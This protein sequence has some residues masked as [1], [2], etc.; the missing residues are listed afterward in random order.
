MGTAWSS[1]LLALGPYSCTSHLGG[2]FTGQRLCLVLSFTEKFSPLFL[3]P[4]GLVI[5]EATLNTT[6]DQSSFYFKSFHLISHFPIEEYPQFS[7]ICQTQP[8][9]KEE[10]PGSGCLFLS[11]AGDE[12]VPFCEGLGIAYS[13]P[14]P[15][16]L[17]PTQRVEQASPHP[18]RPTGE[19]G[20][21]M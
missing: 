19:P 15:T 6:W 20:D 13:Q 5:L 18:L 21:L 3:R 4:Q 1:R 10:L 7:A 16:G 17:N 11:E 8:G 14:A 9:S 2:M 12:V